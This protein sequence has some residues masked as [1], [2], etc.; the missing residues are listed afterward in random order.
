[1]FQIVAPNVLIDLINE[2][3]VT[4][5][6]YKGKEKIDIALF[7]DDVSLWMDKNRNMITD[8]YLPFCVLSVGIVPVQV[9]AFMYGMF[10]GKALEKNGLNIKSI[11]SKVD[12]DEIMRE[13]E[14]NVGFHNG[15]LGDNL[16]EDIDDNNQQGKRK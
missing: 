13:M 11:L 2:E 16:R 5:D 9:S 8:K 3:K 14:R 1:M 12:K 6:L 7:L 4:L 15:L 10:V